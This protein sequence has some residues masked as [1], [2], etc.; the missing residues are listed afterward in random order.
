MSAFSAFLKRGPPKYALEYAVF[1]HTAMTTK[2][3]VSHY[4]ASMDAKRRVCYIF[5]TQEIVS[6]K[7]KNCDSL[8]EKQNNIYSSWRIPSQ[9][10][11]LN[12]KDSPR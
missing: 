4:L 2:I 7:D 6:W 11:V 12:G 1:G 9:S 3:G 8:Q 10:S 5:R